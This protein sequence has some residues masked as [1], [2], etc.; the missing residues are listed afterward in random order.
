MQR[1]AAALDDGAMTNTR[2]GDGYKA[3]RF[4]L[5]G[6]AAI[7]ALVFAGVKFA[8]LWTG[9]PFPV[10]DPATTARHLDARTQVVYDA[11]ALPAGATLDSRQYQGIRA[12]IYDCHERGLAHAPDNML[13]TAPNE[14]RTAAVSASWLLTGIPRPEGVEAI[15]RARNTLTGQGWTEILYDESHGDVRLKL[16][17]PTTGPDSVPDTVY[18]DFHGNGL[19]EV[20]ANA[21]CARYR[22]DTPV[23][24]EGKPQN[25]PRPT[26]PAQLRRP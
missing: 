19:F 8:E 23:D 2:G 10:A 17:P 4:A 5:G 14:P 16:K 22:N 15:Q 13:D 1:P 24:T 26:A 6:L 3:V 21:E 7:A 9:A 20:A 11:L 18:I 25:L 12:D